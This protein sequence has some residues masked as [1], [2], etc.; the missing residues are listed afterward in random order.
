[1]LALD[2]SWLPYNLNWKLMITVDLYSLLLIAATA[3]FLHTFKLLDFKLIISCCNLRLWEWAKWNIVCSLSSVSKNTYAVKSY[4][5]LFV[6]GLLQNWQYC[7][8][9]N[10]TKCIFYILTDISIS[11]YKLH[12]YIYISLHTSIIH[13][14]L[15]HG[16]T[17]CASLVRIIHQRAWCW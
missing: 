12:T 6:S 7:F 9:W 17:N 13:L 4:L 11:K 15:H 1:M 2:F 5:L 3:Q 16:M 14:T 8:K 10:Q